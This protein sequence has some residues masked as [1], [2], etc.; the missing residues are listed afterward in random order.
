MFRSS[1]LYFG[2]ILIIIYPSLQYSDVV[3][4]K[5]IN[6]EM[7][8][9]K[10]IMKR[11]LGKH[12]STLDEYIHCEQKRSNAHHGMVVNKRLREFIDSRKKFHRFAHLVLK[13]IFNEVS[14]QAT[15]QAL[16]VLEKWNKEYSITI[17][18]PIFVEE[19]S[20]LSYIKLIEKENSLIEIMNRSLFLY[21]FVLQTIIIHSTLQDGYENSL[22]EM[23]GR[24]GLLKR[25]SEN[26]RR[27]VDI[28]ME[29]AQNYMWS[30]TGLTVNRVKG[31]LISEL[32]IKYQAIGEM[33]M[34]YYAAMILKNISV[35]INN[36][37]IELSK[38][39]NNVLNKLN[40]SAVVITV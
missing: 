32:K 30:L 2:F 40:Q 9:A 35:D 5:V 6:S 11:Q 20:N 8:Y 10:S 28:Y 15:L 37:R 12:N 19:Y 23:E 4:M 21:I 39:W 3:K 1:F 36:K 25:L 34:N 33:N 29:C 27:I 31:T 16:Q 18:F 13:D 38:Q 14:S 26:R 24:L 7:N 17:N 22:R